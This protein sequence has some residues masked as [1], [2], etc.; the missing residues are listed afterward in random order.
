M[1]RM[2]EK[3]LYELAKEFP[4]KT[5]RELEKYRD[6]DRQEEAQQVPL[7]ESQK[8][9]EDLEPIAKGTCITAEMRKDRTPS[10]K[11]K[12]YWS[13][14]EEKKKRQEAE[15][16]LS[17]MKGIET[18]RVKEVQARCDHLQNELD[19]VKKENNNLYIRVAD[20][21]EVNE[22]HRKLNGKLQTRLTE[23]EEENKKIQEHLNKQ[24]ENARKSGM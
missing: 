13:W 16:E 6:A 12:Y 2:K 11:N 8:K 3:T 15:G 9:Q 1:S 22:Y 19:R 7:T 17:I 4:N 20:S 5:Y 14:R 10:D 24:V 18:N 23:L 21:L